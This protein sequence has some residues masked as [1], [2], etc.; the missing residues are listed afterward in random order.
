MSKS[1]EYKMLQLVYNDDW[2][3]FMDLVA[4]V[5]QFC[6]KSKLQSIRVNASKLYALRHK[7]TISR[8]DIFMV[9]EN[10]K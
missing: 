5:E 9:L 4:S 6:V 1:D 8:K 10:G 7:K 2:I 3:T